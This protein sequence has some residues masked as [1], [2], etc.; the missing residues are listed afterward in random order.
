MPRLE[1]VASLSRVSPAVKFPVFS[2]D[3][4]SVTKLDIPGDVYAVRPAAGETVAL[5]TKYDLALADVTGNSIEPTWSK[6]DLVVQR[7]RLSSVKAVAERIGRDVFGDAAAFGVEIESDPDARRALLVFRF[8]IPRE[9]R[10]RR[11]AFVDRYVAETSIPSGAPTPV[12]AW[13]YTRAIPA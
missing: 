11:A 1:S 2:D 5:V 9:M 8:T 12:L 3:A 13:T 6:P 4:S 10:E 7:Y